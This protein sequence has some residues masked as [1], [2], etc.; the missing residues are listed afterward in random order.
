MVGS[1]TAYC[2]GRM[3]CALVLVIGKS[4]TYAASYLATPVVAGDAR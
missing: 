3:G 4:E 2:G 1:A